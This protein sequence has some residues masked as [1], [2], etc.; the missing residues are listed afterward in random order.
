[1]QGE[2]REPHFLSP[3]FVFSSFFP[4]AVMERL[5]VATNRKLATT[6]EPPTYRDEVL[7]IIGGVMMTSSLFSQVSREAAFP[8]IPTSATRL[9]ESGLRRC[10]R[11]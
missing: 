10:L 3:G 9:V 11:R 6:G 2:A 7:A 4:S 5:L 1:M 8:P